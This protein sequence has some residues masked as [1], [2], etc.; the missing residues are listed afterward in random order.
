M[1]AG[2]S[3]EDL[4]DWELVA[5][6]RYALYR[7]GGD[8]AKELAKNPTVLVVNDTVF[9]HGGLLP[10]HGEPPKHT[11]HIRDTYTHRQMVNNV[12]GLACLA[13]CLDIVSTFSRSD[14]G[15]LAVPVV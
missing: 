6:V 3:E 4:K 11:F 2:L 10:R 8:L 7:P 15:H 14:A 13:C 5:R 9:A 12:S 1:Y